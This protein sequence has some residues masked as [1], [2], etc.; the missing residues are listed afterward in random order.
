MS[1]LQVVPA[2]MAVHREVPAPMAAPGAQGPPEGPREG[3][4]SQGEAVAIKGPHRLFGMSQDLPLLAV[5][6]VP[7]DW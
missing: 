3:L 5:S 4:P 1:R 7:G 2:L 6:N